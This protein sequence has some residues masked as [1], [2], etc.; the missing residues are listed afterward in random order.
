MLKHSYKEY[1]LIITV[2]T[3]YVYL[4]VDDG[5]NSLLLWRKH[6]N[7]NSLITSLLFV[8][9]FYERMCL[10]AKEEQQ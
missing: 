2:V 4:L 9:V 7:G 8:D 3:P 5:D 6:D 1:A 10:L